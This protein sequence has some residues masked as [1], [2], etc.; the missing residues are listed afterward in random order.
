[1]SDSVVKCVKCAFIKVNGERCKNNV[2]SGS[3]FC[4]VKHKHLPIVSDD[5]EVDSSDIH[6]IVEPAPMLIQNEDGDNDLRL[7]VLQLQNEIGRLLQEMAGLR[8][9]N[10]Q[11]E[12]NL[13]LAQHIMQ[14]SRPDEAEMA[15]I[16]K[17]RAKKACMKFYHQHNSDPRIKEELASLYAPGAKIPWH[18]VKKLTDR[19]FNKMAAVAQ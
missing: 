16:S 3:D 15:M 12:M 14:E 5:E 7:K 4:H 8:L 10:E 2:V 11:L 13:N 9:K 19:E 6:L 1:M 17:M 18:V